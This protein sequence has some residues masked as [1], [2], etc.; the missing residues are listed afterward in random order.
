MPG[1]YTGILRIS[2]VSVIYA[3]V[4]IRGLQ[5]LCYKC[6]SPK[7]A[8]EGC[9]C[10]ANSYYKRVKPWMVQ[11]AAEFLA[12]NHSAVMLSRLLGPTG[13][14]SHDPAAIGAD[15]FGYAIGDL[16]DFL[17]SES[18]LSPARPNA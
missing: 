8:L 1:Y 18:L 5:N 15:S 6:D 12:A 9:H 17:E 11:K 2:I 4:Y 13:A 10:D 7:Q 14:F 3:G 16:L